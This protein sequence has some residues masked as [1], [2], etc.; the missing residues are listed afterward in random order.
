MPEEGEGA[1]VKTSQD[2]TIIQPGN[3]WTPAG[4]K[5]SDLTVVFPQAVEI[6]S[7]LMTDVNAPLKFLAS[8]IPANEDE[9]V[10]Y[11]DEKREPEVCCNMLYEYKFIC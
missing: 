1:F 7:V 3:D 2:G 8:Y 9:Y 4:K 11:K 10:P 5:N 6:T